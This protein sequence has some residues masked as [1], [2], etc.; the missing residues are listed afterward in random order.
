MTVSESTALAGRQERDVGVSAGFTLSTTSRPDGGWGEEQGPGGSWDGWASPARMDWKPSLTW[1]RRALPP[2]QPTELHQTLSYPGRGLGPL[3][4]QAS[5]QNKTEG[6]FLLSSQ[7]QGNV[8]HRIQLCL[9]TLRVCC[10][11]CAQDVR[12]V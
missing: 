3:L 5:L 10:R 9:V 12:M 6:Q 7:R 8:A 4:S 1:N 2:P 11:G